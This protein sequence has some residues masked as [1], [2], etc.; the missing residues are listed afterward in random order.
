M[1]PAHRLHMKSAPYT[2]VTN[3]SRRILNRRSRHRHAVMLLLDITF[4]QIDESKCIDRNCYIAQPPL[5]FDSFYRSWQ[6]RQ[7]ARQTM[8]K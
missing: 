1:H 5:H 6:L 3:H 7:I 2:T 4:F 8:T